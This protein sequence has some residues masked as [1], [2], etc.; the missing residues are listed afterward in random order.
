MTS[1]PRRVVN[2]QSILKAAEAYQVE[3]VRSAQGDADRFLQVL[4]EYRKAPDITET[5]LYLE[6][7]EL[8]EKTN[9]V[10]PADGSFFKLLK[11]K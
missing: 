3:R 4:A 2:A 5:R 11:G 7:M 10:L 8:S 9:I 6:T 1:S